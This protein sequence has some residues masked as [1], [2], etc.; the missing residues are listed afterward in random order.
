MK[1]ERNDDYGPEKVDL[2]VG[3]LV[4]DGDVWCVK[5][6]CLSFRVSFI[7]VKCVG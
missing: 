4:L 1:V 6:S 2:C 3:L 7:G 5:K